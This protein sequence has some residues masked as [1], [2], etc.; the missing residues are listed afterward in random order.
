MA[1]Q[2]NKTIPVAQ[3]IFAKNFKLARLAASLSQQDIQRITGLSQPYLS[4]LE[5][6]RVGIGID[7]MAILSQAVQVPLFH[8]LQPDFF[9]TYDLTSDAIWQLY[10]QFIDNSQNVPYERKLFARHLQ[11]SREALQLSKTDMAQLT[12]MAKDFLRAVEREEVDISINSA[13]KLVQSVGKPLYQLLIP[14]PLESSD[15]FL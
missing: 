9:K 5:R 13:I 14:K 6:F 11:E 7:T 1:T 8:L 3:R 12:G 15:L 2:L 10:Q 4:D